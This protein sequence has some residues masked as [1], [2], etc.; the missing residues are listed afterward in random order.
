MKKL[1]GLL[2]AGTMLFAGIGT[3]QALD[4]QP[5]GP[6]LDPVTKTATKDCKVGS[7]R[8]FTLKHTARFIPNNLGT[9]C[10]V[11]NHSISAINLSSKLQNN[12]IISKTVSAD[13]FTCNG[14]G[15]TLYNSKNR[16][17]FTELE[18]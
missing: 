11:Q 5:R 16:W 4:S 17:A 18:Y 6:Q 12:V 1:L 13:G 2:F 14:R 3:V 9:A 8:L 10:S 7:L 15:Y